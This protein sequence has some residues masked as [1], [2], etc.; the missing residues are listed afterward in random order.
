V[1]ALLLC[2]SAAADADGDGANK[3]SAD[4]EARK[5]EQVKPLMKMKIFPGGRKFDPA[6]FAMAFT[7]DG[8]ARELDLTNPWVQ[9][10]PKR[11]RGN[12]NLAPI[13]RLKELE[14][15]TI[16]RVL[17]TD[18]SP[19]AELEALRHLKIAD[20]PKLRTLRPLAKLKGSLRSLWLENV[21]MRGL[22]AIALL[23]DLVEL[24]LVRMP[25]TDLAPLAAL[26][27]L[28]KVW[29]TH[30]TR[31]TDLSVLAKL[32]E[33]EELHVEGSAT[34]DFTP[35]ATHKKLRKFSVTAGIDTTPIQKIDGIEIE[36]ISP[37]R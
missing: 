5:V 12:T 15:L 25:I 32:P 16:A 2:A 36:R 11:L 6:E 30:D 21:P 34:K 35:L 37:A 23:R 26:T 1:G 18:G 13:S 31:L 3:K 17:F 29:L 28:R 7:E 22:A 27:K 9:R 24:R 14:K 33:L 19:I 8:T 4:V 20:A 10:M